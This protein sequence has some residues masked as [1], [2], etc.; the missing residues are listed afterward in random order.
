MHGA[1]KE[2]ESCEDDGEQIST[3]YL[4]MYLIKRQSDSQ[5]YLL[6]EIPFMHLTKYKYLKKQIQLM[7]T[8]PQNY[9]SYFISAESLKFYVFYHLRDTFD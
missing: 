5:F 7:L 1:F 8:S 9:I 4:K 3:R 2:K 6:R